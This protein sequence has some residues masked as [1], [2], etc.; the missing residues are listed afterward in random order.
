MPHQ[1]HGESTTQR[2]LKVHVPD[3]IG[4]FQRGRGWLKKLPHLEHG[5]RL[6]RVVE[7]G[8]VVQDVAEPLD[9]AAIRLAAG[10]DLVENVLRQGFDQISNL[11][12]AKM[13]KKI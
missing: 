12:G 11:R 4:K 7:R 10:L 8:L 3:L 5:E 6:W 9:V 13:Y 2:G 1:E